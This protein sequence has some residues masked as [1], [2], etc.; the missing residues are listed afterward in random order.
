MTSPA[1]EKKIEVKDKTCAHVNENLLTIDHIQVE[2]I[3]EPYLKQKLFKKYGDKLVYYAIGKDKD[4]NPQ[5]YNKRENP[6][7]DNYIMWVVYQIPQ[8]MKFCMRKI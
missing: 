7:K 4:E 5:K 6:G 1:N 3:A 2:S 8:V